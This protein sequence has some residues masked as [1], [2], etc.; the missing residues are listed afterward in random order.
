MRIIAGKFRGRKL[1]NFKAEHIRPTTDRVKESIFNKLQGEW[2]SAEV[3]DLYAGTGNL[4]VEAI[5][6]GALSV[7]SVEKNRKSVQIMKKNQD[8]FE[9]NKTMHIVEKDVFRFLKETRAS[10]NIIMVDPPFTEKLADSTMEAICNS[11]VYS[12]SSTIFI[13]SSKQEIIKDI[14]GPLVRIDFREFGDKLVSFF[15]VKEEDET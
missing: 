14:Y 1:T 8:L 6:R 5:S 7:V 15:Q 10:F 9:L 4:S 2:E 12:K 3:L 13:E 11:Q